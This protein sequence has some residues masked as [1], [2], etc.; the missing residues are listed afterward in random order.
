MSHQRWRWRH[1]SNAS[2]PTIQV[3]T[4][5]SKRITLR[6]GSTRHIQERGNPPPPLQ[7]GR[8]MQ[9]VE[10]V[11]YMWSTR[12]IM[13]ELGWTILVFIPKGNTYTRGIGLLETLWKVVETIIDTRL[14]AS[15]QFHNFLHG[16]CMG[17]GM[18]AETMQLNLAQDLDKVS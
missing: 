12:Y 16:L 11:Q 15:I 18:G 2:V 7:P 9:L 13:M 14:H 8:W 4:P 17:R 5:T 6:R 10:I 1:H 3:A